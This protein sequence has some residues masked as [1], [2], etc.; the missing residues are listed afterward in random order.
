[1][2]GLVQVK[3]L[4]SQDID[5]L[6]GITAGGGVGDAMIAAKGG[7]VAKPAQS[8]HSPGETGQRPDPFGM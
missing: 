2:Q 8:H 6:A 1:M 4:A 3:G 5:D 7:A